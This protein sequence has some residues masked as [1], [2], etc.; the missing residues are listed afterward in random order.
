MQMK[1]AVARPSGP[2]RPQKQGPKNDSPTYHEAVITLSR[3]TRI[4]F[5]LTCNTNGFY[6]LGQWYI[7]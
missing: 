1:R 7:Q 4:F 3:N 6:I 5:I 2:E